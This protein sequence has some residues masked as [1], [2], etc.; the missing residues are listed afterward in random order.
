MYEADIPKGAGLLLGVWRVII[1][2][3]MSART[4]NI[5]PVLVEAWTF[6][7]AAAGVSY[8]RTWEDGRKWQRTVEV[9]TL[10]IRSTST[11]AVLASQAHQGSR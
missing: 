2:R 7:S 8:T 1:G 4:R 9:D 6:V 11:A 10:R 5:F 3:L